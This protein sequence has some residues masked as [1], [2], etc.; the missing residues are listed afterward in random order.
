MIRLATDVGGT[1]TDLLGYDEQTGQVYSAKSL[2][3]IDD[4][5]RGVVDTIDAARTSDGLEPGQVG[6]FVHGGTTVI[7]AITERK[8]VRTALVTTRGIRDVL[9]IGRGTRPDLYNLRFHT[10]A[11]YVERALRFE[12]GE[13]IGADGSVLE[14][15]NQD[16]MERVAKALQAEGVEAV[17]ILFL[18]SYANPEHEAA[19][20]AYLSDRLPDTTICCSH[21]ISS[22]WREYERS[23]TVVLNAYVKPIISRY[24][25]KLETK[26][27]DATVRCAHYAMLSNGG[28]ASFRQASDAPLNLVESGPSG[29]VAGAVRIGEF[30]GEQN[31]LAFDVGGTTAKCSVIVDGKPRVFSEYKMEWSRQSPGYPVQVPVVDIVEIGSGGGSIARV[32]EFGALTVG[33]E[34][35]GSKPGPVCYGFGGTE[36]T[37]TDA[38]LLTGVIN[39]DNFAGGK[40]RLDVEA[41]REAMSGL[42]ERLGLN[43]ENTAQ[44][45]LDLAEANMINALKLVTIQ[46][47]Y[48]PR[49]FTLV[50]TGGGGPLFA[51]S[52]GR[53]LNAKRVVIPPHAGI[54][55]AWGM[56]AAKPRVDMR[57]TWFRELGAEAIA[58][59]ERELNTLR[60]SATG[61]FGQD[62]DEALTFVVALQLRYRGQEHSVTTHVG[63]KLDPASIA[64][65]FHAAHKTAYSF[66][67]VGTAIEIT[68]I[69]L[70]AELQSPVISC[71]TVNGDGLTK[72]TAQTGL[73]KVFEGAERGWVDSNVFHREKMPPGLEIAGPALIEE[74]T[75][76][77]LI[78]TGQTVQRNEHGL[79]IVTEKGDT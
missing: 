46:R 67:L 8:G 29:G 51:A 34:S 3:T 44:A 70:V 58:P 15:I 2:T 18:N 16:D 74:P 5:S 32:D 66:D 72:E 35:A 62:T 10:P 47:G 65:H 50:V 59:L 36:P 48:D 52:L 17:A 25:Q 60:Q 79:L 20:A 26:L 57:K 56:L 31:V 76:T 40:I 64:D 11:P 37:V 39:P 14:R 75:T 7:N 55:S 28:V 73:R 45:I 68:G 63:T 9:E 61:Y 77:T 78:L 6:F 30:L 27:I 42:G 23:N 53:E 24:F 13:R 69:H 41:A 54:F 49:D 21:E 43:V 12:I 1:F 22:L 19:C 71:H 33:P 4:Q 38:K